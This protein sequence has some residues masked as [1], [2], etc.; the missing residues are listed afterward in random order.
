[1]CYNQHDLFLSEVV[2]RTSFAHRAY[3][4]DAI[5]RRFAPHPLPS[6]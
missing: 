5:D 4:V 2:E 1:M 3:L 6:R